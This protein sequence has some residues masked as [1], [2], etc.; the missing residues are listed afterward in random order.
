[1][2]E[3]RYTPTELIQMYAE[4]L[5]DKDEQRKMRR[6][7]RSPGEPYEVTVRFLT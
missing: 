7:T 5:Q 6:L 1:M 2:D 3:P 4:F